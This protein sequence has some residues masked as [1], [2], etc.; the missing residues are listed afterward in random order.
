MTPLVSVGV[1]TLQADTPG[2]GYIVVFD[3]TG[4]TIYN[5]A[6]NFNVNLP[7]HLTTL[8]TPTPV[9]MNNITLTSNAF[10][11]SAAGIGYIFDKVC[12]HARYDARFEKKKL[13]CQ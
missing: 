13:L 11:Q 9:S 1:Y 10:S 2:P 8:S 5:V 7:S 3:S 6:D 12:C 4:G